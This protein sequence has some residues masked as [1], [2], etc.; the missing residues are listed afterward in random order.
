[1]SPCSCTGRGQLKCDGTSAET[2]FRLSAKRTIP[3]KS[4]GVSVQSTAGSRGVRI[5]GSNGSN[6]GYTMS[7]GSVK[8]TGYPLH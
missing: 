3:F 7:R 8:D 4:K 2:G 1:M 6:A 5:G